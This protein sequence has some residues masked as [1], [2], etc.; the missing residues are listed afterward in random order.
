M[1]QVAVL[2]Y[3]RLITPIYRQSQQLAS[4]IIKFHYSSPSADR[5][6]PR[7]VEYAQAFASLTRAARPTLSAA[8]TAQSP[9]AELPRQCQFV[10]C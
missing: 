7:A 9:N 4:H 5:S 3:A 8:R 1:T 2:D 6:T 10:K